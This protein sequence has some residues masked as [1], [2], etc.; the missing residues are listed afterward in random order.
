MCIECL[1]I[2]NVIHFKIAPE[3]SGPNRCLLGCRTIKMV[4]KCS[5]LLSQLASPT[6][7]DRRNSVLRYCVIWWVESVALWPVLVGQFSLDCP[8]MQRVRCAR[9]ELLEHPALWKPAGNQHRTHRCHSPSASQSNPS[10]LLVCKEKITLGAKKQ[11]KPRPGQ[12]P[13][14][15]WKLSN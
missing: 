12:N 15:H 13:V 5:N 8:R 9:G 4:C 11:T 10:H 2:S 3:G 6:F 14:I 1:L 7:P